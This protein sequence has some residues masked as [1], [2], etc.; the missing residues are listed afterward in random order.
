MPKSLSKKGYKCAVLKRKTSMTIL[1][2]SYFFSNP[3]LL[4]HHDLEGKCKLLQQQ[5]ALV[6]QLMR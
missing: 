6:L 1:K 3:L 5:T 2:Q 4:M